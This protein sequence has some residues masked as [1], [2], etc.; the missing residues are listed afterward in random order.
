MQM[1]LAE[2]NEKI[3]AMRESGATYRQIADSY[4]LCVESVRRI[5]LKL[6]DK[7]EN[8]ESYP[9]FKK[10]VSKRVQNALTWHFQSESI[11]ENPQII[12]DMDSGKL[13]KIYNLGRKSL[14]EIEDALRTIGCMKK[15][16]G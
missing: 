16:R 14:K 6:K 13:L 11:L 10:L 4:G 12:A 8:S 2:R 5:Y 1:N 15:A 9:T 7:K 3:F